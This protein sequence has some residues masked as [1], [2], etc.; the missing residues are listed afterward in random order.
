EVRRVRHHKIEDSALKFICG[1]KQTS[2]VLQAETKAE[3][4]DWITA[5]ESRFPL[6]KNLATSAVAARSE[7]E[8]NPPTTDEKQRN[9]DAALKSSEGSRPD[10]SVQNHPILPQHYLL[11]P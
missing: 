8:Q 2:Y 10:A 11:L 9:D 3:L 1:A 5:F 6:N 7:D 4:K